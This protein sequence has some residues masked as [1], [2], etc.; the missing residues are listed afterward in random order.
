M[1]R[2]YWESRYSGR[3]CWSLRPHEQAFNLATAHPA[4]LLVAMLWLCAP[5]LVAAVE[6]GALPV[7]SLQG[8]SPLDLP[9]LGVFHVAGLGS[10]LM[11]YD[12]SHCSWDEGTRIARCP[13]K[14]AAVA[15]SGATGGAG[16]LSSESGLAALAASLSTNLLSLATALLQ[17]SLVFRFE[18]SRRSASVTAEALGL[19][20]PTASLLTSHRGGVWRWEGREMVPLMTKAGRRN[21]GNLHKLA[22]AARARSRRTVTL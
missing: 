21:R 5:S 13:L 1:S 8:G 10:P 18:P 4:L 9:F 7:S 20:A 14:G 22:A 3:T 11:L 15:W 16:G 2:D 12:T 19:S 17:P 6:P